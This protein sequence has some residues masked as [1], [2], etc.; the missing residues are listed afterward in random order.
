M[1]DLTLYS[2]AFYD[3]KKK[4]TEEFFASKGACPHHKNNVEAEAY[5]HV[6]LP[7]LLEKPIAVDI[8]RRGPWVV[9]KLNAFVRVAV[10]DALAKDGVIQVLNSVLLPPKPGTKVEDERDLWDGEREVEVDELTERLAPYVEG[11]KQDQ[12]IP[13]WEL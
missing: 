11:Q 7:T 9:M 2:T 13:N 3:G 12:N 10:Q 1:P 4:N 6:D 5:K 8:I